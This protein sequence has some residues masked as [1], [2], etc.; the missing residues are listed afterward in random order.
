MLLLS[1]TAQDFSLFQK[2]QHFLV[3]GS[4]GYGNVIPLTDF[5]RGDN[6]QNVPIDR[7]K[8]YSVKLLW[9]NPGY[10]HWQ[11]VF[12]SPYYGIGYTY[13]TFFNEKEVGTPMSGYGILG[14]PWFRTNN[15]AF[16][17][18][19]QFGMTFNWEKY[20]PV[21]NPKN[22]VV[23]GGITLHLDIGLKL[24]Y[25]MNARMDVGAGLSFIHF[26]NGG[27]ERP[28]RGF[29]IYSPQVDIGYRFA[30]KPLYQEISRAEKQKRRNDLMFMI[31]Y[32]D[33]QLIELP[34]DSNY[35]AFA[36]I[37][38]FYFR[39]FSNAFRIGI[40]ADANYWWG[41]NA[42]ADGTYAGYSFENITLGYIIQPELII[43][44]LSLVGGIGIYARHRNFGNYKQ[45]YQRLGVR[46]D[47]ND[48]LSLGMNVRAIKFM[49]AEVLEFNAAY[50]FSW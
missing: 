10:T 1:A 20:D 25:H 13:G 22:L 24:K 40:G 28:N 5:V 44:R 27:M 42:H 12:R 49:R 23:G 6:L 18:E 15:L 33:Y 30:N 31:S 45:L 26:S 17:S 34:L 39:Q 14:I 41:L 19:F 21:T 7:F 38:V 16:Y 37:S 47:L 3:S 35:F 46:F 11:R 50:R 43:D 36:G 2:K 32:G 9:Q 29:N 48:H 8:Y 4:Y